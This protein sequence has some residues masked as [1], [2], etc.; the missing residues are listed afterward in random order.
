[1]KLLNNTVPTPNPSF[2]DGIPESTKEA[3]KISGGLS[4]PSKMP[5]YAFNLPAIRCKTGK[6]LVKV[7]GSV[8]H[9]CYA[10]KGRYLFPATKAAM[11]R[12][13]QAMLDPYWAEAM[14]YLIKVRT[15][16]IKYFRWHDSGDL[17]SVNHLEKIC[18]IAK[19]TPDVKHW[20]PTREYKFVTEFI[21]QYGR[22]AIPDNLCIRISAHM[23]GQ[24]PHKIFGLVASTVDSEIGYKCPAPTQGNNCG[25]C[26]ACWD[27]SVI[28]V[29]YHK[30]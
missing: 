28:N 13:Y 7:K 8:C 25:D 21:K 29:D 27:K 15:K 2:I 1:M 23:V 3:E 20:L 5:G 17:Q 6:K 26:R 14:I 9:G 18:R 10:L 4:K 11:E 12:R 19:Q 16:K 22:K 30:H 24:K